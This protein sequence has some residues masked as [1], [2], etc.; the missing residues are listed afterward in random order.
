VENCIVRDMEIRGFYA[1]YSDF[2]NVTGCEFF[3]NSDGVYISQSNEGIIDDCD[4]HD[5][6]DDGIDI[7]ESFNPHVEFTDVHNNTDNGIY[8][9][10]ADGALI[11]HCNIYDNDDKGFYLTDSDL[12]RIAE[13]EVYSNVYDGLYASV[14]DRLLLTESEFHDNGYHGASIYASHGPRIWGC[15]FYS[16]PNTGLHIESTDLALIQNSVIHHNTYGSYIQESELASLYNCSFYNNTDM[17][18]YST[19]SYRTY[20]SGS[21]FTNNTGSWS[22]NFYLSSYTMVNCNITDNSNSGLATEQSNGALRYCNIEGNPTYGARSWV[23]ILNATDNWWGDATG[24]YHTTNPG[25]LGDE[26]SNNIDYDPW[27]VE[28]FQ[29]SPLL[30]DLRCRVL[31]N[32]ANSTVYVPTGNIYDDS[33]FYAFYAYK[34]APQLVSAP[35]QSPSDLW[36]NPDGSPKFEGDIITFG[37]RIANRMV[38]YYEDAGIAKVGYA[39]NG[40]HHLFTKIGDGST[41]LGVEPTYN[42]A[43]KDYFVFQVYSDGDRLV[44][45]EWGIHAEGTYAGGV[46]WIDVILPRLGTYTEGYHIFSWTDANGDGKPQPWEIQVEVSG[47][48]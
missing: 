21:S 26:V 3:N 16:N 32:P 24:P 29:P 5:N 23:T 45:S 14:S 40:T 37:G 27:L 19:N 47:S 44:L 41:I 38:A 12:W 30:S 2:F 28:P 35:T 10:N 15:D 13:C 8:S 11:D 18:L 17:G 39:Y 42:P 9:W 7:R 22:C 48:Y 25:G 31:R 36:L 43:E 33:T 20:I 4:I 6:R 46:C 34:D 1:Y